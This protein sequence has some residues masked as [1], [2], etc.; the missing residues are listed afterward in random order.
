MAHDIVRENSTPAD[1]VRQL[2]DQAERTLPMLRAQGTAASALLRACD[3]CWEEL[4]TGERSVSELGRAMPGACT[5]VRA[6]AAPVQGVWRG[7]LHTKA[8]HEH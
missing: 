4:V 2:L 7:Q 1:Q 5:H 3:E 8:E 6:P